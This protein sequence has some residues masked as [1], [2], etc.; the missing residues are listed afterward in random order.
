MLGAARTLPAPFLFFS[1]TQPL[2]SLRC[3][4]RSP[5]VPD[6]RNSPRDAAR[7]PSARLGSNPSP[8]S[9]GSGSI[10]SSC[11]LR[12]SLDL[13]GPFSCLAH[14]FAGSRWLSSPAQARRPPQFFHWCHTISG[15]TPLCFVTF[16]FPAASFFL[17]CPPCPLEHSCNF[18]VALIPEICD[19]GGANRL[20]VSSYIFRALS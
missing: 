5:L 12:P 6:A 15:H 2:P 13:L 10:T 19:S 4:A 8:I 3:L 9:K 16:H 20:T 14:P 1:R 18:C 11:V 7:F 17:S